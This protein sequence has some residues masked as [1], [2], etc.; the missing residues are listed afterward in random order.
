M[1]FA[2]V[3]AILGRIVAKIVSACRLLAFAIMA[4]IASILVI[5]VALRLV[6]NMSLTWVGE[7]CSLLLVWLMLSVAPLGFHEQFHIAI[8]IVTNKAP[9]RVR[10]WLLLFANLC[11]GAF[12]AISFYYGILSTISELQVRLVSLPITR[13]WFTAMLPV[14]SAAV[15]L[16]CLDNIFTL[17]CRG[18]LP[19]H[20]SRQ[21]A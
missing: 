9:H 20:S 5:R 3:A 1:P 16:V 14:S 18:D 7:S 10:R 13:G 11:T 21:P 2:L 17:V 6:L 4:W 12:F 15:L 8:D 19:P